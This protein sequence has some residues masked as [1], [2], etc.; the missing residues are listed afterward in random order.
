MLITRINI[1]DWD[2][3]YKFIAERKPIDVDAGILCDWCNTADTIY[4]DGEFIYNNDAITHSFWAT[5]GFKATMEN[6]D[7]IEVE[8][9]KTI[10]GDELV[11][12]GKNYK[13]LQL[14][15]QKEIEDM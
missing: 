4:E 11:E 3:L 15:R 8:C 5:P 14:K 12:Y 9:S 6:E 7:V 2:K 13:L 10:S 1:F